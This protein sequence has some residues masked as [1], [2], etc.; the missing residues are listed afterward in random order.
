MRELI[1][2]WP[3]KIYHCHLSEIYG[4]LLGRCRRGEIEV[5]EGQG[6]GLASVVNKDGWGVFWRGG[7]RLLGLVCFLQ[8]RRKGEEK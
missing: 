4:V 1:R 6:A 7:G 2:I 5:S 3:W 8:K